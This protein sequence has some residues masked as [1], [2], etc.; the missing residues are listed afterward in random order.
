MAFSIKY[1]CPKMVEL[2]DGIVL[3]AKI[4]GITAV[5]PEDLWEG[6]AY[7]CSCQTR[8]DKLSDGDVETIADPNATKDQYHGR[9][10]VVETP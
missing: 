5:T 1:E 6:D 10:V 3:G 2:G 8:Q 4:A 7:S 9:A